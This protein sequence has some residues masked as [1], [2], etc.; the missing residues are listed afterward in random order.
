MGK[1]FI[2]YSRN[3]LEVVDKFA[4]SLQQAG[5][6]TWIDRESIKV[7]NSWRKEI[8]EAIDNCD[9]FVFIMSSNSIASKNVHKE[10]IL[11]QD[12]GKPIY[13]VMLEVVRLP[14][15]IRYQLAGLQFIN[16]PLLGFEKSA[17]QLIEALKPHQKKTKPDE[18]KQ[19]ELVIQ[20]ID[21]SAFTAEKQAE[22]LAFISKLTDTDTSQLKIANV[23]AGSVHVFVDMP[24]DSA[25]QLKT[26][27]LNQDTRFAQLQITY[28][29]IVGDK[30]YI[31]ISFGTFTSTTSK[32]SFNKLVFTFFIVLITLLG[33]G[34]FVLRFS[35]PQPIPTPTP[36]S[37]LT[38][39]LTFEPVT[40]S[41]LTPTVESVATA[42]LTQIPTQ[43]L[44][45]EPVIMNAIVAEHLSCNH[46]PGQYF[47]Y[48][49]GF[50]EGLNLT[51]YGKD[52]HSEW[53]YVQGNGYEGNCWVNLNQITL[54]GN[55]D[56]LKVLYPGEVGLP[57][58]FIWPLPQ[59][60]YTARTA[61]RTRIAIYWDE[62]IL[63]DGEIESPN[64]ARYLLELWTCKNSE[65]TFEAKFVWDD[66]IVIEDEAGCSEPSHGVIY[67][68]EKHG[69]AG[70]VEIPWTAP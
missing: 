44:T 11:S 70:P 15:E 36:A 40:T 5:I 4:T 66:D 27:A 34:F 60:V 51:V 52:I 19:A 26:F 67:L 63:P 6:D 1:I 55:V 69:Y 10:I 22:L 65:L 7:G 46:G 24:A 37:T 49:Y 42:T 54:D 64:S 30:N 56:N 45:P 47:L 35:E 23:V 16:F 25:I 41:T 28:L 8:V 14:A 17:E 57:L 21:I 53:G 50:I 20:G 58:S 62:Y 61:D 13:V 12:S 33:I 43:T 68:V 18:N 38:A 48:R 9:A 59:N 32:K 2:S 29:K 39:T 31:N 3:D